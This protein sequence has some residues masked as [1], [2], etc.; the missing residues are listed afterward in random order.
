MLLAVSP[1]SLSRRARPSFQHL[2]YFGGI[3]AR[4]LTHEQVDVF[5]HDHVADQREFPASANLVQHFH[6]LIAR[7]SRLEIARGDSS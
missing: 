3:K 6:K 7:V 4:R 1:V 5:G 2:Q